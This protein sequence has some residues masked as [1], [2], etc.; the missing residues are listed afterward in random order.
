M[1]ARNEVQCDSSC[2]LKLS[3]LSPV[4]SFWRRS[5]VHKVMSQGIMVMTTGYPDTTHPTQSQIVRICMGS[6][7]KI[8]KTVKMHIPHKN[9]FYKRQ[10]S[11]F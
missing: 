6:Y 2:K 7:R 4:N 8:S 9:M 5:F 11:K 1:K 10:F 3:I